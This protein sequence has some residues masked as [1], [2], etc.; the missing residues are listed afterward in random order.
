MFLWVKLMLH[1]IRQQVTLDDLET[2]LEEL[3]SGLDS[4]YDRILSTM[5]NLPA[6]QAEIVARVLQWT[7]SATRPLALSELEVALTVRFGS[8]SSK[9]NKRNTLMNIRQLIT[10]AMCPAARD[11]R[12]EWNGPVCSRFRPSISSGYLGAGRP[13]T[14]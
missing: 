4:V 14:I 6:A 1:H 9:S 5:A 7:Y 13:Q 8:K 3:P 11:P 2:A 10:R 12:T